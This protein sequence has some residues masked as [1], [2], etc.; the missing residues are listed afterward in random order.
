MF[1]QSHRI[2]ESHLYDLQCHS[3]WGYGMALTFAV[4]R[5]KGMCSVMCTETGSMTCAISMITI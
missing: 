4:Y 2:H 1:L 3:S 5:V